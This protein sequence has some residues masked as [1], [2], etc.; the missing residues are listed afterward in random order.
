M[1]TLHK[2]ALKIWWNLKQNWCAIIRIVLISGR[3]VKCCFLNGYPMIIC[4]RRL[5]LKSYL[6]INYFTANKLCMHD[7]KGIDIINWAFVDPGVLVAT[8][9]YR[10]WSDNLRF[11][12]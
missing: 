4:H 3:L 6:P 12:K 8:F 2:V 7:M 5:P 10:R 1:L 9:S 11:S